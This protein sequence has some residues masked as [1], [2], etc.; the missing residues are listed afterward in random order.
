MVLGKYISALLSL[1]FPKTC[2]GCGGYLVEGEREVCLKCLCE[3][4][5]TGFHK[6]QDNDAERLFWGKVK[7]EHATAYCRFVK[8]GVSQQL[9]HNLKYKGYKQLGVELGRIMGAEV[10][11]HPVAQADVIVPVPLHSSKLRQRGYNQA[12]M[13][14]RGLAEV[15]KLPVETTSLARTRKNETQTHKNINER[16]L[17]SIGL[18]AL[19]GDAQSLS[20]KRVLL[21]DDVITTGATLEACT[22]ELLKIDGVS[23]N[24]MAFAI[25]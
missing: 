7:V 19:T 16:Y 8:G 15:L 25:A 6:E 4:G 20:G 14:A 10:K 24:C 21:V 3:L 18:F 17:N 1:V 11:G 22:R 9:L 23:V 5:V 13:I 12:E 2:G